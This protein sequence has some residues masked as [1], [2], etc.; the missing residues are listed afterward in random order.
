MSKFITNIQNNYTKP[1]KLKEKSKFISSYKIQ[2]YNI[3][4]SNATRNPQT[5]HKS[6]LIKNE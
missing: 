2:S 5:E 4:I 6:R 1:N 3:I